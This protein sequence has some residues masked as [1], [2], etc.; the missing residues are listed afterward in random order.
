MMSDSQTNIFPGLERTHLLKETRKGIAKDTLKNADPEPN[1]GNDPADNDS[2]CEPSIDKMPDHDDAAAGIAEPGVADDK[3]ADRIAA[4]DEEAANGPGWVDDNI[5]H[6]FNDHMMKTALDLYN[7]AKAIM[8]PDD[9]R[10]KMIE[11]AL[12]TW[13]LKVISKVDRHKGSPK[14]NAKLDE[15]MKQD[16][17]I[18]FKAMVS[19]SQVQELNTAEWTSYGKLIET[20]ASIFITDTAD[21]VVCTIAQLAM[22]WSAEAKFGL[23]V[24]DEATM[25][26]EAQLVQLWRDG[27]PLI[28][29]GDQ[30]QL[31]VVCLSKPKTNPFVDQIKYPPFVRFIDNDWPYSMLLEVMRMTVGLEALCSDLFYGGELKPG[32][33]TAIDHPSRQMSRTW[34][35]KIHERYPTLKPE[36]EGSVYPV[37]F[38][39]SSTS[40]HELSGGFSL[41]NK[42]NVAVV[43]QHVCWV[44]ETGIAKAHQIGIATPYG[45]QVHLY[46]GAFKG[47]AKERPEP[48]NDI[49]VGTAEWWQGRQ[50]DY[51][52]VDLVRGTNDQGGLGFMADARRLN[53]LLSRQRQ[54]LVIVGDKACTDPASIDR[55]EINQINSRNRPVIKVFEWMEA[56]GRLVNV[57]K[58][59]NVDEDTSTGNITAN[60][61]GEPTTNDVADNWGWGG[62]GTS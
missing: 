53:V 44:I 46:K 41:I 27:C 62:G 42:S 55:R 37:L 31:G 8:K 49:S 38:N 39:I 11:S 33:S 59:A 32:A 19:K 4:L 12:W 23:I 15:L 43:V 16:N 61:A 50:A 54:A 5:S 24:V 20:C 56:K 10:M 7:Q 48:F 17:F 36:P 1:D 30:V 40:Q 35:T 2:D 29:I 34:H 26:N 6:K 58:R 21:A 25:M 3:H 9:P 52:I 22:D 13:L 60:T 18:E 45:G 57:D 28:S 51:I 47:L 14:V